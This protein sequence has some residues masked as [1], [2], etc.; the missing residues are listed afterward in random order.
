MA[1]LLQDFIVYLDYN[2]Q[3]RLFPDGRWFV[4]IQNK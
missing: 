2:G 1:L 3:Y 4:W